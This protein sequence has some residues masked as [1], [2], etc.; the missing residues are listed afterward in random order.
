VT[1]VTNVTLFWLPSRLPDPDGS[2][3]LGPDYQVSGFCQAFQ[4]FK[5]IIFFRGNPKSTDQSVASNSPT[6]A[7]LAHEM[8]DMQIRHHGWIP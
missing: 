7:Q 3:I 4:F 6:C 1:C 5:K 2:Q 8:P